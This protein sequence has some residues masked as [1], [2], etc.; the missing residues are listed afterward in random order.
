MLRGKQRRSGRGVCQ[1]LRHACV[2]VINGDLV[3]IRIL[4]IA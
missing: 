1:A 3:E 2:E 4:H